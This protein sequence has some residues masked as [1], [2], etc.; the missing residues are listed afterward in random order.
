M[1]NFIV[2]KHTSPN[3]K[4]YIG[5]TSQS[6]QNRCRNGLGYSNNKYFTRAI[7]KYGWNN[8][9]HK[10]LFKNLTEKEAKEKE[11]ELIKQYKSNDKR[12][13]YNISSGGEAHTGCKHTELIKEKWSKMKRGVKSYK[14]KTIYQFSPNGDFIKKWDCV[15]EAGRTLNIN[16]SHIAACA[17][18][19]R[20]TAGGYVWSYKNYKKTL[21]S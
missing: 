6:L 10:I 17:R 11:I 9:V 12:Y 8:F 20:K 18:C 2:Y 13:G 5:I 19:E 3:G 15:R 1:K 4:V 16:S 21:V 7:E 14:A